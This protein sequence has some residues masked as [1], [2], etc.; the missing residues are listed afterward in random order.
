M[1]SFGQHVQRTKP[2][3]ISRT[4]TI[5]VAFCTDMVGTSPQI[6]LIASTGQI[7]ICLGFSSK[8]ASDLSRFCFHPNSLFICQANLFFFSSQF[9]FVSSSVFLARTAGYA[10][11]NTYNEASA[12]TINRLSRFW[13]EQNTDMEGKKVSRPKE[14]WERWF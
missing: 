4:R 12:A 3:P 7:P 13:S 6:V 5:C 2:W 1:K 9:S 8:L 14:D 11:L 10:A